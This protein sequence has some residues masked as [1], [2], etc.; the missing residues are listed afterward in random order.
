M[1]RMMVPAAHRL[2]IDVLVLEKGEDSPAGK[3]GA[4]HI[5]GDWA[6][7]DTCRRFASEVDLLTLDHEFAPLE[8]LRAAASVAPLYPG[9][10]TMEKI[11]DKLRQ[12]ECLAAAGIPVVESRGFETE[13]EWR[14]VLE[15]YGLPVMAKTRGGGYDGKGNFLVESPITLEGLRN[16]LRGPLYAERFYPYQKEIAVMVA[17]DRQGNVLTYPVVETVQENHICV[18]VHLGPELPKAVVAKAQELAARAAEAVDSVGVL[19]VEMFVSAEGEV[20]VNEL[21]PRPHNSGHYTLDCCLTCQFENHVRAVCG[22]P[23]GDPSPTVERAVMI[24]LLGDGEGSGFPQGLAQALSHPRAKL[25]LYGKTA[26]LGRKLGHLTLTGSQSLH[27]LQA[28]ALEVASKLTF[29]EPQ[30]R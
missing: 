29:K 21:A 7:P 5:A 3:A 19:G 28:E 23:L 16:E 25:H 27:D 1:A 26:K 22:L 18:A 4:R 15:D 24:N 11:A 20:V 30:I 10:A 14:A 13:S 2:G 9:V 6:C 17:R 12:K 8:A